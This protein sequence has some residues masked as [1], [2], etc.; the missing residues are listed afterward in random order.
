MYQAVYLRF[1]LDLQQEIQDFLFNEERNKQ[2][3]EEFL[4]RL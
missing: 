3:F 4:T 1:S 2:V